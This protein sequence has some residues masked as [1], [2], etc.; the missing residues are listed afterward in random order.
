MGERMKSSRTGLLAAVFVCMAGPDVSAAPFVAPA[1]GPVAF[2][3]DRVPLDVETMAALSRQ[4]ET[5]ARGFSPE[6]PEERRGMAQM[7]ALAVALD[8]ENPSARQLLESRVAGEGAA[9]ANP[10]ELE[11]TKVRIRQLVAW[12]ETPGAGADGRALAAC[13]RDIMRFADPE[14]PQAVAAGAGGEKGAWEGWVPGLSA[15]GEAAEDMESLAENREE[16]EGKPAV[17]VS[18][19]LGEMVVT[20]PL[21]VIDPETKAGILAP[22]PLRIGRVSPEAGADEKPATRFS[23]SMEAD[24]AG[25]PFREML[26]G[27]EASL[28]QVH[29]GLPAGVFVISTGDGSP[30]LFSRNKLAAGGAVLVLANAAVTGKEPSAVVIGAVGEDGSFH[31]FPR[32][33]DHLRALSSAEG[34]RLVVPEDAAEHLSAILALEEPGFFLRHEVFT[35]GSVRELL[36]IAGGE[37]PAGIAGASANFREIQEKAGAQPAG[38][39]IANRFVRQRLGEIS[40]AAPGHASARMLSVQAAGSRPVVLPRMILAAELRRALEPMD[41]LAR[42]GG[43]VLA[44]GQADQIDPTYEECRAAIDALGR[45]VDTADR[46]LFV[47]ARDLSTSVRSLGRAYRVRLNAITGTQAVAAEQANL[48]R[49]Y[50]EFLAELSVLEGEETAGAGPVDGDAVGAE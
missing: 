8:P 43:R 6:T 2:R 14:H 33:W 26:R 41:W 13:L 20:A 22:V 35:A 10:E 27:L 37:V 28:G 29:G 17:E 49:A 25:R 21:W 15:Y 12:L 34:C 36:E 9:A 32:F 38:Q 3:R 5:L 31:V 19:S 16:Q 4:T 50:R 11:K 1:D 46:A 47:K 44:G 24:R 42:Q 30:Y 40:Q 39:Y 48:I 23:L 45:Y 18:P 7:L